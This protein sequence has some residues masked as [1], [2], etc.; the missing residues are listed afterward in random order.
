MKLLTPVLALSSVLLLAGCSS[1]APAT[2]GLVDIYVMQMHEY[3]PGEE[4]RELISMGTSLCTAASAGVSDSEL[5][6]VFERQGYTAGESGTMVRLTI[7]YLCP[8]NA[9]NL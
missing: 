2:V 6:G 9:R 5:A 1:P 3:F 8:E 7:D 4:P